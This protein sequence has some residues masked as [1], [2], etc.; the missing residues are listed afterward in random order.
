MKNE[1]VSARSR[2]EELNRFIAELKSRIEQGINEIGKCK[3]I[4]QAYDAEIAEG[5]MR[6]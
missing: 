1:F 5:A 4:L 6:E 2:Q 3:Q